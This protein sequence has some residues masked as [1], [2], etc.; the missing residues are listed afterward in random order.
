MRS[1]RWKAASDCCPLWRDPLHLGDMSFH[2]RLSEIADHAHGAPVKVLSLEYF[3]G[4]LYPDFIEGFR[5]SVMNAV[6]GNDQI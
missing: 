2:D 4:V 1:E 5:C 6:A 3:W